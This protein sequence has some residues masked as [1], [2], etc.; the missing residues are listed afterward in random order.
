[1]AHGRRTLV[2]G[3]TLLLIGAGVACKSRPTAD[4]GATETK[5]VELLKKPAIDLSRGGAGFPLQ[6][7]SFPLTADALALALRDGYARRLESPNSV[8]IEVE[9]GPVLGV[10]ERLVIDISHS[11]VRPDFVPSPQPK[12][13]EPVAFLR[14]GLMRYVADPLNYQ[15]FTAGMR[16]EADDAVLGVMPAGDGTFGLSLVDCAT[17]HASLRLSMDGLRQSLAKGVR[18]QQSVAF[19]VNGIDL[20]LSSDHPRA[21]V[22]D[23][24]VYARVLF[25]P[26][27]FRITGRIDID[28]AF[29][30]HFKNLNAAGLNPTG[31]IVA[32]VVQTRLDKLNGKAA[33]LLKLPGDR[34]RLTGLAMDVGEALTIDADLVG[35]GL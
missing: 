21:L 25:L 6:T 9:A 24:V 32:G 3:L 16:L 19:S 29:N 35:G 13:N 2:L 11:A 30:V 28:D 20:D 14:A 10:L 33:P 7:T 4:A 15:H 34:I 23:V 17:A 26:A 31:R 18:T 27:N 5:Q 12:E 8:R 1:M 22:A